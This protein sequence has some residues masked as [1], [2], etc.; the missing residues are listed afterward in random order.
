[1]KKLCFNDKMCL[2]ISSTDDNKLLEVFYGTVPSGKKKK[3]PL[4]VG[5]SIP[6]VIN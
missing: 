6:I 2:S 4:Q 5:Y 3:I 1:M